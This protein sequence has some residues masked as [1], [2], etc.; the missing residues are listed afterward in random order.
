MK[1]IIQF[2]HAQTNPYAEELIQKKLDK[3]ENRYDFVISA[4][5]IFREEKDTTNGKGK[6]CSIDISI[7]GPRIH[8]SSNE[9]SFEVAAAAAVKDIE[10]QLKRHKEEMKTH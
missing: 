10:P 5:V 1:T 4:D 8:A 9:E 3:L 6:T 7:P 2:V